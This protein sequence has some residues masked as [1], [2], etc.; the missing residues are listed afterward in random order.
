MVRNHVGVVGWTEARRGRLD[1]GRADGELV[2]RLTERAQAWL[3]RAVDPSCAGVGH[4]QRAFV[5]LWCVW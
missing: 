5:W 2:Q 1:V 4:W 3:E